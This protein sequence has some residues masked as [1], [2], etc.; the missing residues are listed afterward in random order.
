MRS[1]WDGSRLWLSAYA[2]DVFGYLVT[3]RLIEEG[4]YEVRSSVSSQIS[5]GQP[6]QVDPPVEER[7]IGQV[8]DLL[9]AAFRHAGA[10]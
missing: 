1:E 6:E 5:F 4:G 7:I 8:A 2:H 3:P 10:E 9:P